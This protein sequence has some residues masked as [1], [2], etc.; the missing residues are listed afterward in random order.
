[1]DRYLLAV[2]LLLVLQIRAG[3]VCRGDRGVVVAAE[4]VQVWI[5][6]QISCDPISLFIEFQPHLFHLVLHHTAGQV[7]L[8]QVVEIQICANLFTRHNEG[9]HGGGL[10][11]SVIL[12]R[13]ELSGIAQLD[14][15]AVLITDSAVGNLPVGFPVHKA[16]LDGQ[17]QGGARFLQLVQLFQNKAGHLIALPRFG[18]VDVDPPQTAVGHGEFR[19]AGVAAVATLRRFFICVG[20]LIAVVGGGDAVDRSHGNRSIL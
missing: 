2:P 11:P 15:V 13:N 19:P 12:N 20:H 16:Q 18:D 7:V 1:M 9:L 8:G 3:R 10:F 6:V 17:G 4:G 14:G 5:F